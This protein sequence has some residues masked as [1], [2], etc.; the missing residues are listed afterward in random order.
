[1]TNSDDCSGLYP[2]CIEGNTTA[3]TDELNHCQGNEGLLVHDHDTSGEQ[4][5]N[6]EISH[7]EASFT[8]GHEDE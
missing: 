1:V 7:N 6:D 3:E 5:T 4:A 8:V 2:T